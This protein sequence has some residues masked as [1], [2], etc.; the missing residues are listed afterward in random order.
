MKKVTVNAVVPENKEKGV[1]EMQATVIVDFPETLEEAKK[2]GYTDEVILS[3]ALANWKVTVQSNIRGALKRGEAPAAIAARL[4]AAKMGV[5]QTGA[6]IDP[7][8]AYLA[9]FAAATP[10]EQKKMIADLQA[11]AVKK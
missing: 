6:K 11:K 7:V 9:Q 1:K 8:Q 10:E 5:A 4:A 2:M 3:N